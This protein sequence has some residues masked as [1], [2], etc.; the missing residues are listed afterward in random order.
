MKKNRQKIGILWGGGLGDLLMLRPLL[1]GIHAAADCD[2]RLLTTATHAAGLF[3]EFCG[4]TGVVPLSRSAAGLL[5]AVRTWRGFFDLLY[6]GPYPTLNTRALARLLNPAEI[7]SVRHRQAHPF[8]LEQVLCDCEDMELQPPA[9]QA[10][11][12]ALLPWPV[13]AGGASAWP[14]SRPFLV[15]HAGSKQRWETTRW[16]AEKWAALAGRLLRA[17]P[18][19][20][21]F[22][23]VASE[24][25]LLR[26]I[27]DKLSPQERVRLCLDRD[28]RATAELVAAARGVICHNSGILHLAAFL[29][30][31]TLCLTGSSARYWRPPYPWVKNITSG[32]C[33]L[34]CNRYACPVP[35]Y[36][37]RCIRELEVD[38]V[39]AAALEH[40]RPA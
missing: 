8:V 23:G 1:A 17:T 40:I 2:S 16:P 24:E 31:R 4:P 7:L 6:L 9:R 27:T 20:L 30:A 13:A 22:V 3:R 5:E 36:H 38:E 32:R 33:D 35:F 37:S 34:A 29:G 15:L 19:S 12:R 26:R 14:D 25:A 39:W 28:M 21:A 18:F 10:D 11:F